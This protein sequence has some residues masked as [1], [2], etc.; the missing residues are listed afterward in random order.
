MVTSV[1]FANGDFMTTRF[2]YRITVLS[3]INA[4]LGFSIIMGYLPLCSSVHISTTPTQCCFFINGIEWESFGGCLHPYYYFHIIFNI[5]YILPW[6]IVIRWKFV[7]VCV[8]MML[9]ADCTR[10]PTFQSTY[11]DITIRVWRLM[12]TRNKNMVVFLVHFLFLCPYAM[13]D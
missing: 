3:C 11:Y 1:N 12:Q 6:A 10:A 9:P 13:F 8:R 5:E 7:C 4:V 2:F